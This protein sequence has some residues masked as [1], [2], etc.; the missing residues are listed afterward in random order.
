MLHR[1]LEPPRLDLVAKAVG[2]LKGECLYRWLNE[3]E[4][5]SAVLTNLMRLIYSERLDLQRAFPDV[6]E[7]SLQCRDRIDPRTT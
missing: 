4:Q 7:V 6:E 3:P 1:S 2:T 5:P